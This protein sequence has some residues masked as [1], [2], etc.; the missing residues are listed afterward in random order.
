M[1][2][3]VTGG[4]HG[5]GKGVAKMLASLD[6]Q[7]HEVIIL[8]R[9]S[10]LG[11]ATIREF[12]ADT[13]NVKTAYVLCDLASLDDVKRAIL[14]IQSKHTYL[15]GIFINAGIG[16]AAK[17]VETVDGM[18]SHF[19]VN[20]LSQFMLTLNLLSLLEKSEQG[21]R[22]VFNATETGELFWDDLQM[23]NKWDFESAIHQAMV[24]K[25]MFLLKLD[26]LYQNKTDTKVAF[27]GF[28]I[29]ETVWTNQINLIPKFMKI[30]ATLMNKLGKFITIEKCGE[31]IAP[32]FC[33]DKDA[34]REKSGKFITWKKDKFVTIAEDEAVL[35][36]EL[37][38]RLWEISLKL[39][40]DE[41]T[42]Q[43]AKSLSA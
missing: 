3:L 5:M 14:E 43:I 13:K 29:H 24:A 8:C 9:S 32:L 23:K 4:T 21:A 17:R 27:L 16:Y 35:N 39:C 36:Q 10:E 42:N 33:E 2:V 6:R 31:V 7:E 11:E 19:Q 22:V 18:D 26:R 15:D 37:Q 41:C 40:D 1:K 12:E 30:M 25:R 38:D 28:Q 20:Y 34:S